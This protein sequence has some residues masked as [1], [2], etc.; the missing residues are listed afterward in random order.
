VGF[1]LYW[2][3]FA[4]LIMTFPTGRFAPRWTA[5]LLLLW[6]AQLLLFDTILSSLPIFVCDQ[7]AVYGSAYAVLFYRYQHY[8][9]FGQRQ[10]T[11]WLIYG[12][13]LANSLLILWWA[14]LAA[15]PALNTPSSLYLVA[16]PILEIL[17]Y[18][19]VPVAIG[20]ALLRY[21]LWDIDVL[22]NRTV[23]YGV[24]TATLIATYL[25][26]VLGGQY[27]VSSL[28]GPGNGIILVVSTLVVAV[29]FQPLRQ[30]IQDLVDRRF[31]RRKYDAAQV[32]ASFGDTLREEVG[33][34]ELSGLLLDV[35]Q[36]TMQPTSVSL[37]LSP[38]QPQEELGASERL[39]R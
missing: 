23:V 9:S 10:Q 16:G 12:F 24:V 22:I 13:V 38:R 15:V 30:R 3:A 31:Y 37:W 32:V 4:T 17:S 21:R 26:L 29:L 14:I 36:E 35:V 25:I 33:L 39:L 7:I 5:L 19:I 11:K 6:L 27:L 8:Y 1:A 34:V 20:I 2:P 28:L 18:L